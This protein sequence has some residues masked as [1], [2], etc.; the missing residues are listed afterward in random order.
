MQN[1]IDE[2]RRKNYE[3]KQQNNYL[4][5]KL[6]FSHL[7]LKINFLDNKM[8]IKLFNFMYLDPDLS[9]F[10]HPCKIN[11]HPHP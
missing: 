1:K 2:K 9:N 4:C 3:F 10:V 5:R 8:L 6:Y 7:D 11:Q